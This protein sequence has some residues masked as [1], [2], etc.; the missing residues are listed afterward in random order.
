M[1]SQLV[2]RND[3]ARGG[4]GGRGRGR[5][6]RPEHQ[7]VTDKQSHPPTRK[8]CGRRQHA[9][10][11]ATGRPQREAERRHFVEH[12]GDPLH[13]GCQSTEP[14][15]TTA[16]AVGCVVLRRAATECCGLRRTLDVQV[17][18]IQRTSAASE[19]VP[20]LRTAVVAAGTWSV[21]CRLASHLQS[22]Q[23]SVAHLAL[24]RSQPRG[25]R[26]GMQIG[27]R[28]VRRG[29]TLMAV[30]AVLDGSAA[31]AQSLAVGEKASPPRSALEAPQQARATYFD[32]WGLHLALGGASFWERPAPQPTV[33]AFLSAG[34]H[35]GRSLGRRC[36]LPSQRSTRAPHCGGLPASRHP[37]A[38]WDRE[39]VHGG[40]RGSSSGHDA[41]RGGVCPRY[42]RI[43][44][45]T[46]LPLLGGFVKVR[47]RSNRVPCTI[48]FAGSRRPA[49]HDGRRR[50][51]R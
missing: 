15:T 30:L 6:H 38:R 2:F 11:P 10:E 36:R 25:R 37:V 14:H 39:G 18:Y 19:V 13:G 9:Y 47:R 23:P 16:Y 40:R 27:S 3:V 48:P 49:Q 35:L 4:L 43:R 8:P 33:A 7:G 29:I 20:F 46:H 28:V 17:M 1:R 21:L 44:G 26:D 24:A 32:R 42:L 31:V 45:G 12:V 51:S 5:D 34:L 50:G 22:R 41:R